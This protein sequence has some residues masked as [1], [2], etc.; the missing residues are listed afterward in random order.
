M[1]KNIIYSLAGIAAIAVVAG[2]VWRLQKAPAPQPENQAPPA[3]QSPVQASQTAAP[4]STQP[5][6]PAPK[7]TYTQ[8]LE[9]YKD[10]RMQFDADCV[11][12]P[13]NV[14]YKNPVTLMLDNRAPV[15]RKIVIN[16]RSYSLGAY[17]FAI[18]SI[19]A[20]PLPKE[21]SVQCGGK[22]NAARILMQK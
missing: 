22:Y 3:A 18:A 4:P 2:I 15:A 9:Q 7:L 11:A 5:A 8:A 14:T 20:K 6:K 21:L 10:R 12:T 16:G 19:S 1:N 17:G 13:N